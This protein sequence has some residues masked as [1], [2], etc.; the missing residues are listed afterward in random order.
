[1]IEYSMP[2][3]EQSFEVSCQGGLDLVSNTLELLKTPGAATTLQNFEPAV[4]GGYRRINGYSK[5]SALQPDTTANTILGVHTYA[6]GLI[7]VQQG[8]LYWSTDGT[9]WLQINKETGVGGQ[10]EADLEAN[11]NTL[12]KNTTSRVGFELY[13]GLQDYGEVIIYNGI[14]DVSH[15]Y[16]TDIGG[17][18]KYFYTDLDEATTSAYSSAIDSE[19]YNERI[20]LAQGH[21]VEWSTRYTSNDFLGASAGEVDVGEKVIGIKRFR[22]KLIIFCKRSIHQ[23]QGLDDGPSLQPIARNIGCLDKNTIQEI[24]GDLIF[25]AADGLRTLAGTARI[26]DVEL[27]T[28]S[29]KILPIIRD[30]LANVNNYELSSIVLRTKNQYR[31]YYPSPSISAQDAKG[32][33][34]T[35]KYTAEGMQWEW[36][37][38]KGIA[39]VSLTAEYRNEDIDEDTYFGGYDGYIYKHDYNTSFN[40]SNINAKFKT[41]DTDFGDIGIQKNLHWLRVSIKPE[42]EIDLTVKL[43]FDYEDSETHQ[44]TAYPILDITTPALFGVAIFNTHRFGATLIPNKKVNLEGSGYSSSFNFF[45][46]DTNPSYNIQSFYIDF[47]PTQRR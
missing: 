44:P 19:V 10:L 24:G 13:E 14:N 38:T 40:G 18:R 29:H 11:T 39:P 17:S 6:D 16:I 7:A 47:I 3:R 31:L 8:N 34:G 5:F 45:T 33:I 35:L 4:N 2:S 1:M 43:K 27:S 25:L 30:L 15:F 46:N 22:D 32:I 20:I 36:S 26:D 23:L 42:G 37:E 9:S 28:I 41:P 12:V 21:K